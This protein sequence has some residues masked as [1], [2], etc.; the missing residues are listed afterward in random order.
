[1]AV[2]GISLATSLGI[3]GGICIICFLIFS[4]LRVAPLT[5]KFYMPKRFDSEVKRKPKRLGLGLLSWI[6]PVILYPE[7]QILKVAGMDVVVMNRLLVYG[8][9]LFAFCTLWCCAVLMPINGT[10]GYLPSVPSQ[11]NG[12]PGVIYSDLDI[13]S[14][15]NIGPRD[16]RFWA[17]LITAYVVSIVALALLQAFSNDVSR[18]RARYISTIPRGGPSH[19]VL[20]TDI[21][22]VDGVGALPGVGAVRRVADKMEA[23]LGK[24]REKI[25]T[26]GDAKDVDAE[27][28]SGVAAPSSSVDAHDDFVAI[29]DSVLDPWENARNQLAQGDVPT[30]V[31]DEMQTIYGAQGV[32]AV[33]VV[34]DTRKVEPVLAKYDATKGKLED[35][36]NDI[37]GKLKR[38]EQHKI[39]RKQVTLLPAITPQWAKDKYHVAAKSVKVDA[40][41]YLPQELEHLYQQLVQERDAAAGSYLPAAFITFN[42]RFSANTAANGLQTY[43]ETAWRVQPAPGDDE[44][45]WPNLAMRYRQRVARAFVMLCLFVAILI[46]YLPVTAAIQAVVNLDNVRAVPGLGLVTRIPFVTQVLQGILP[47]LVLKIFLIL[48][49]PILTAMA[50]FQGMTSVSQIDFS[51]GS[52]Y[53]VSGPI[54][55]S[56]KYEVNQPLV[57]CYTL[58]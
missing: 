6:K 5:R 17:H 12:Q 29:E 56:L 47:S 22:C 51:I 49:P 50:K 57:S 1:M 18:L 20:V 38:K 37:I 26:D 9:T 8:L 34:A 45:V 52:E 4:C 14:A 11:P 10:A 2:T 32:A 36:T 39:K 58:K 42:D 27:A 19:S 23:H 28:G 7:D 24:A 15:S 40:L 30:M 48:L 41:E 53:C 43:D 35:I 31:R 44:I 16:S 3:N 55:I 21:P 33:N 13:I 25:F 46:F 54:A